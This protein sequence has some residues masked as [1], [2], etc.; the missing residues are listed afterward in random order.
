M[1]TLLSYGMGVDSTAILLNWLENPA[2]R[3]YIRR[4]LVTGGV[5]PTFRKIGTG[6]VDLNDLTVITAMTG[7]EFPDLKPLIET[8]ILPRLRAHGIRFVQVARR[9]LKEKLTILDDTTQPYTLY[10][11]G[12]Y[13]LSDEMLVNATIPQYRTGS[14]RCSLK[15]KGDP[16]DMWIKGFVGDSKFSHALGFD[17]QEHSRVTTDLSY[18]RSNRWRKGQKT[19][20]YPLFDWEWT[21]EIC[22]QFIKDLTGEDW[23]KSA[24]T[25][26]PFTMGEDQVMTR[27]WQYPEEAAKGVFMEYCAMALNHRQTIYPKGNTLLGAVHGAGFDGVLQRF[28]DMLNESP[29]AL[30][31]VRR[32]YYAPTK[33]YRSIRAIAQG[34][35][36]EIQNQQ[37]AAYGNVSMEGGI[38][39][40][41][42]IQRIE[43][44][45]PVLEEMIAAA[46]HMA[47]DKDNRREYDT[48]WEQALAGD[49]SFLHERYRPDEDE[50][51]EIEEE[52]EVQTPQ[53]GRT[54]VAA[55]D[56]P[57]A[58]TEDDD[59]SG[60]AQWM[61][62]LSD[63][64]RIPYLPQCPR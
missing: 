49:W 31:W 46:P 62:D 54:L 41:I 6:E 11:D 43:D 59:R 61:C 16:L 53:L 22:H 17:A 45:Y 25:Y 44:Q 13:K 26:C 57:A 51:E 19:S 52:H 7:D 3:K 1:T 4:T 42:R 10:L 64:L 48:I 28:E 20:F 37:L 60:E 50:A 30:Y 24:C 9:S 8:H 58:V 47:Q 23:P 21:R 15:Y 35:R 14:R 40:V 2:S 36:D 38:P 34:T 5:R 32:I 63:I 18:S 56:I 33:A 27:F 29:W 39:R 12:D 55:R